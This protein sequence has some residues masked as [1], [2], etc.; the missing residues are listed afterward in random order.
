MYPRVPI[1]VE[2]SDGLIEN[3][4]LRIRQDLR[5]GTNGKKSRDESNKWGKRTGA[6]DILMVHEDPTGRKMFNF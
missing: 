5:V 6:T 2:G 4:K 3:G 1:L